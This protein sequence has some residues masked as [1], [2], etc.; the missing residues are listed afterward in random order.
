MIKWISLAML[1][2]IGLFYALAGWNTVE[3]GEYGIK[4]Q[5]FGENKGVQKEGLSVGTWWVDPTLFDVEVYDTKAHQYPMEIHSTTKDG[6][7]VKVTVTFEISLQH[8]KVKDIHS[9]IGRDYY[10]RV[11]EPAARAAIRDALPTQLSDMVYTDEGRMLIQES[12]VSD[13]AAKRIQARGIL[14]S[15]NLQEVRFLNDDFLKVLE[16]KASAAQYEEIQL[17]EALAAAQ[18]AIKVANVAEG[19]KQKRIKAAE[20]QREEMRLEGEGNRLRD[21]E[22][23]AGILALRT[24]EAK[25]IELRRLALAGRGGAELVSIAWAENLGPNVKVYGVPTGAPNTNTFLFDEAL[26]GLAGA[27]AVG[28]S[29]K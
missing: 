27:A 6:Q 17:R 12:I 20:A 26:R 4:I 25:G 18:E 5:Q 3:P 15:V 8:D 28:V 19:E 7:P 22:A 11:V 14:V 13:L 2:V 23:A 29:Q 16:R 9:L 10:N 1:G 24:A 21:E